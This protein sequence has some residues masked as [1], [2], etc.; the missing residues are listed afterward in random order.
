[1]ELAKDGRE[2]TGGV[3]VHD[4]LAFVLTSVEAPVREREKPE[5]GEFDGASGLPEAALEVP[6][7]RRRERSSRRLVGLERDEHE[8]NGE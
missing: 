7:E 3:A 5:V 2:L 8:R 6:L 1:M 4:E